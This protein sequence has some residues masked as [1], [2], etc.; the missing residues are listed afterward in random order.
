M[1]YTAECL[2]GMHSAC[3]CENACACRCH[4]RDL[5]ERDEATSMDYEAEAEYG[6]E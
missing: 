4:L 5:L 2:H 6:P 3:Q 1:A